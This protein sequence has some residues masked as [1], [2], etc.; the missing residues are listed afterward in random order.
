LGSAS[1][2]FA[3]IAKSH[4]LEL[5]MFYFAVIF[6]AGL[7]LSLCE[8]FDRAFGRGLRALQGLSMAFWGSSFF[9]ITG[10]ILGMAMNLEHPDSIAF[11]VLGL[12]FG[13]LLAFCLFFPSG[14]SFIESGRLHKAT[15]ICAPAAVFVPIATVAVLKRDWGI[16]AGLFSGFTFGFLFRRIGKSPSA[17]IELSD[18]DVM[19]LCAIGGMSAGFLGGAIAGIPGGLACGAAGPGLFCGISLG[20]AYGVGW[21]A[22][23]FLTPF[24]FRLFIVI[25]FQETI[26][27]H[28]YRYSRPL[29]A[30]YR[31][32]R[33]LCEKCG[34]EIAFTR[35]RGMVILVY[36]DY[37]LEDDEA[38]MRSFEFR[39]PDFSEA[40]DPMDV[41]TIC[42]DA[43]SADPLLI[44]SAIIYLR[45]SAQLSK[46]IESIEI[47][48]R[49]DLKSLGANTANIIKT[50]FINIIC[51]PAT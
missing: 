40:H 16:T 5:S 28:C 14:Q 33:M 27:E 44:E 51:S 24:V 47:R 25:R 1:E 18:L 42:I 20:L 22:Q 23:I 17:S 6:I 3:E 50:N 8:P 37:P 21:L 48:C 12:T 39:D 19:P 15:S 41:T 38:R 9:G 2:S 36:G 11:L 31:H 13:G 29:K 7:C 10:A 45:E 46:G 35:Q 34:N 43:A 49:G 32:G 4:W 30:E 26:C